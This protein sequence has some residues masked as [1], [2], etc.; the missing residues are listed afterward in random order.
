[1]KLSASLIVRN[2][3]DVI[4]RCLKS[5]EGIGE[6]VI[7]DTGSEDNTIEIARKYTDK[8]VSYYGCNHPKTKDGLFMNFADARNASLNLCTGDYILTIDADEELQPGG[9]QA[10]RDRLKTQYALS[11]LC[12]SS[13][14]GEEHRQPRVYKN[15]PTIYW[16]G[17]A[18]NY[19]TCGPGEKT[20]ITITYHFNTQKK[21]DPDRTLRILEHWI[22][23]NP[24]DCRRE[25]FY[26]SKEYNKRGWHKKSIKV[27]NRYLRITGFQEE[28]ADAYIMLARSYAATGKLQKAT[29][30]VMA[31]IH[32]N[33]AN[34]EALTLAG[35]LSGE[36]NRVRWKYLASKATNQ[37][38]LFTR[39]D[40][41]L[42]VTML[43]TNDWAG[44][45][46]RVCKE[47]RRK[48][49]GTIDIEAFTYRESGVFHIPTGP[50]IERVGMEEMQW[51]I[52]TSDIIHYKDDHPHGRMFHG[53]TIPD[54]VRIVQTVSGSYFRQRMKDPN[55]MKQFRWPCTYM[56]KDLHVDGWEYMP[57]PYNRFEY[58]FKRRKKFRVAHIPSSPLK[59]GTHI[60]DAAMELLAQKRTDIEYLYRTGIHYS[61][62]VYLKQSASLYIDQMV[63]QCVAN[64]AYEA[65]G[66]GVPVVSYSDDDIVLSPQNQTPESLADLLNEVLNWHFLE[67]ESVRQY[68]AMYERCGNMGEKWITKYSQL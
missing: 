11:I 46:Y 42:K 2:S 60:I 20:D 14:T 61:E 7:V 8:V 30:S 15:E 34:G 64:A 67:A 62:S 49:G 36:V 29:N 21:K 66:Y 47:V 41:R 17:A 32:L 39:P 26:V 44:S 35:D 28:K 10:I 24:R 68:N 55:F 12:I 38:V 43:S 25:L 16:K 51:R 9:V 56:T 23:N 19:L 4:E 13:R 6:I 57:Q 5:I 37:G 48:S 22:K 40:N 3:S 27:L 63:F 65:M 52:N 18:H 54:H 33:P 1:M 50:A 58:K 45:G 31:A 53:L 59:K